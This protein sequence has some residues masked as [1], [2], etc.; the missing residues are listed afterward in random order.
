MLPA[1]LVSQAGV[2]VTIVAYR[3]VLQKRTQLKQFKHKHL[4]QISNQSSTTLQTVQWNQEIVVTQLLGKMLF[5]RCDLP[6]T[7]NFAIQIGICQCTGD[8]NLSPP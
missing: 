6:Q 7:L 8:S 1:K 5:P 4:G 2:R 3:A